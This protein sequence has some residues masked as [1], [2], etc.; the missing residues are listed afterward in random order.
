MRAALGHAGATV[1]RYLGLAL[2]AALLASCGGGDGTSGPA[3]TLATAIK[4]AATTAPRQLPQVRQLASTAPFTASTLMDWAESALPQ[5]FP[6]PQ[7]NQTLGSYT[8]RYY[9]ATQNFIAVNGDQVYVLGPFTGNQLAFVGTLSGLS[10]TIN[11]STCA[12]VNNVAP[13]TVDAGPT[14]GQV[15]VMYTDV[16]ICV[17]GTSQCQTI[18]HVIVDTGSSGLRVLASVLSLNLPQASSSSGQPLANCIQ[19]VDNSYLWGPVATA[20]VSFAGEKASNLPIQV[21]GDARTG[22]APRACSNGGSPSN[23]PDTFGANGIVGL[24]VFKEDCG[25]TCANTTNNGFYYACPSNGTG[26][27][28]SRATLAQQ[29]KNPIPLFP[30]D[31]NGVIINLPAVAQGGAISVSGNM[32]FGIGTQSNNQLS[33]ES[34]LTLDSSGNFSAVLAGQTMNNSFIDS[35][36]NGIFFDVGGLPSCSS[37]SGAP[38]F[39]CPI[40]RQTLQA[41]NTGRNGTSSTVSFNVDNAANLVRMQSYS[42]F[43]TLAG[44]MGD[45]TAMDWG[46]PFFYGRRVFTAIENQSTPKG[47]GPWVAY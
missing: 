34:V 21:V 19:F 10:C 25:S 41:V 9:P 18:D 45:S 40:S 35:G 38:G 47:T 17:P 23:T 26:C 37:S 44:P 6:G 24:S 39:Y 29:V 11:P 3:S 4:A 28:N 2:L 1:L 12:P 43:G 27:V 33:T 8:Y 7:S 20:D 15:N 14:G 36:S 46:L 30:S 22:T 5:L 31:N 32:V 16:T 13:V 42:A